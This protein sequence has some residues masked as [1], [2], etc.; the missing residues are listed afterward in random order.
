ME[1]DFGLT[2]YASAHALTPVPCLLK[3]MY[4]DFIVQ[5]ILADGTVLHIP[6][7]DAILEA[8]EKVTAKI[9]ES[10]VKPECI[11]DETLATL[12]ERFETKGP[13]VLITVTDLSKE[14]RKSIHVFVRERYGQKLMTETKEAGILVSHGHTQSTRKRRHWDENTP[15]ECHFTMCKEN[16]D[17]SYACQI[18]ARFLNIGQNNIRTHGI[19]DKRGVTAQRV[20]VTHVLESTILQLN[21]KLRGIKVFDCEHKDTPVKMGAHWGNRFSIVLRNIPPESE[22][23]LHERLETFKNTGFINYFG[24]QRF[25]SRCSTTADIGLAIVKRDWEG[26]V[27]KILSNGLPEHLEKS[28][29]GNAVQHFLNTGNAHE[30]KR[31]LKGAQA[32]ATVEANILKCLAKGGTWQESITTAVP[33]QTRSLY[34][35]AYQSLI[36][37]K[38]ASRRV[39]EYDIRVHE[40]DVG[41]DGKPLGEHATHYDIHIPLAGENQ[42][43]ENSYASQWTKELLEVDGLTAASFTSL[44]D[45]FSLGE[46]SRRLFVEA[47]DLKWEIIKY[48]NPR[49]LLQDGLDTRAIPE[50]ERIGDLRALEIQFSLISGS[51]AT[52]A[53]RE[54]TGSDM[55]KQAQRAASCK[56]REGAKQEEDEEEV[57]EGEGE[58][59]QVDLKEEIAEE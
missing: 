13:A 44:K 48:S 57:G 10:V 23:M 37:N 47:K 8:T 4:S 59:I 54:V 9:D 33:V 35:H 17:T 7:P 25:G 19:K 11:S 50:S 5:E 3:E 55:G 27:R 20:S 26:A 16:K 18:I 22:T 43:F 24:T 45:K 38:V 29:V 34:V 21:S 6:S 46:S 1:T 56:A 28:S 2:E 49:D 40:N 36:W 32:F 42:A 12:D 41:A 15:K 30:A 31:E 51:Y 39:K 58:G 14:E 53:L 52:V